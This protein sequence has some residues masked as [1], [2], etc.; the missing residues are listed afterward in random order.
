MSHTCD[1]IYNVVA[2][3][4]FKLARTEQNRTFSKRLS[5]LNKIIPKNTGDIQLLEIVPIY[6]PLIV[7]TLINSRENPNQNSILISIYINY[8]R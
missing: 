7:F 3:G 6:T 2:E 8:E 1:I 5:T 4:A